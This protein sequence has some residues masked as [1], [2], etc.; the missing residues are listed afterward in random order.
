MAR[1]HSVVL[2]WGCQQVSQREK[3]TE[4]M[5]GHRDLCINS[6]LKK[7]VRKWEESPMEKPADMTFKGQKVNRL[8]DEAHAC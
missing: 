4:R 5:N 3:E 1:G 6:L 8:S 7:S 2:D